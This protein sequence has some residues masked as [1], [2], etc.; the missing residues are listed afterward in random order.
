MRWRDEKLESSW[1]NVGSNKRVL[2]TVKEFRVLMGVGWITTRKTYGTQLRLRS[3]LT[4]L[5][6]IVD[7][8]DHDMMEMR[9]GEKKD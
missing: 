7:V 9:D 5:K 1:P 6:Q 3:R 4:N 8:V 2:K